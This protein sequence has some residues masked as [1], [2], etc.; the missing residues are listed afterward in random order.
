MA[1]PSAAPPRWA[2]A[3]ASLAIGV[4]AV[5]AMAGFLR[6]TGRR[7]DLDLLWQ[8]SRFLLAGEDPWSMI[9]PGRTW[10]WASPLYYPG[11]TL[12][13]F[14]PLTGA[15]LETARAL[16]VGG[17]A[18]LLAW[19]VSRQG[20]WRLLVCGSAPFLHAS[21]GGQWSVIVA[22]AFLL[23]PLGVVAVLKPTVGLATVMAAPGDRWPAAAA[24]A[25][26]LLGGISL[27]LAPDWPSAWLAA[28][29]TA[30]HMS[31]PVAHWR[32]GGPLAL[33]ALLRWRRPEARW[34]VALACVPQ[35]TLPYEGLYMLLMAASRAELLA[36][37]ILSYIGSFAHYAIAGQ[38]LSTV[39]LHQL[40]GDVLVLLSYLPA[41][42]L[43]L[44]RPNVGSLPCWLARLS[45]AVSRALRRQT[46]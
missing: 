43:I 25:G 1:D 42:V 10:E 6:T 15:T 45:T 33:L 14:A 30:P 36:L 21:V 37:T 32:V 41:L 23:W 29:S 17:C 8:A 2:R 44:R 31:A 9:G 7:S 4:L 18:A 46:A 34:L 16:W 22:A 3:I 11:T 26:I 5:A 20:W 35:S 19:A 38:H 12:V 13:A 24:V 27:A 39:Q 28:T 40:S